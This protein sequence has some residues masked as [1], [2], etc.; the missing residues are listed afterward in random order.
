M[1]RALAL[2]ERQ[3]TVLCRG[4]AKAGHIAEVKIGEV[5]IRL[6]PAANSQENRPIDG[7]VSPEAFDT[8]EQYLA[9][10]D[11]SGAGGA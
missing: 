7:D 10:R 3:I 8:L 1:S 6:V 4:A 9:W 2:T 5:V 11:R